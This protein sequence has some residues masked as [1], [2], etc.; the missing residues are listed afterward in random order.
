[1][2]SVDNRRG[3]TTNPEGTVAELLTYAELLNTPKL[4]QLYIHIL[5]NGPVAIE[6]IKD[7]LDLP[8]STT[9][10]YVSKLEEMGILTRHEDEPPTTVS[11]D[12]IHLTLD[13]PDGGVLVTPALVDAVARQLDTEDIR[14]FV[15]RQGIA[16][17]AAALHY[18]RR[19]RD[20]GLTQRTAAN[21]LGVHAIE[22]MT[23]ITALQ[24][25]VGAA[26]TDDHSLE[27]DE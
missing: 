2:M 23:V 10:K 11:V 9:Y 7:E 14:V 26:T 20:G 15:E 6:T 22:G 18:T 1:M 25:V 16:K 4:A 12:P 27:S 17:L 21:K 19:V 8:H 3:N 24:D 13:T 5:R